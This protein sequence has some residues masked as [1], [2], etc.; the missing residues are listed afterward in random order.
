MKE[1]GYREA[2][3]MFWFKNGSKRDLKQL[4][5]WTLQAKVLMV[6]RLNKN[7]SV[8]MLPETVT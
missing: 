1:Q 7:G 8:W 2:K 5:V 4:G 3:L 6:M